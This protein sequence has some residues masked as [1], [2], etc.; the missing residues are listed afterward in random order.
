MTWYVA[1][2]KPWRRLELPE[3]L[4]V[5]NDETTEIIECSSFH[6]VFAQ[7]Q[8]DSVLLGRIARELGED[9]ARRWA[10]GDELDLAAEVHRLRKQL[11]AA[12]GTA[13]GYRRT[14]DEAFNSG[15]G[16]YRP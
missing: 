3:P 14:L 10:D 6:D 4:T 5:A 11:A 1:E 8:Q 2:R 16:S 13:A 9:V 15:D 12:E 7:R